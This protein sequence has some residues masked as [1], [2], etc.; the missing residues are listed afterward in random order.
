MARPFHKTVIALAVTAACAQALAGQESATSEVT[1]E[2]VGACTVAAENA[3]FGQIPVDQAGSTIDSTVNLTVNCSNN[4]SYQVALDPTVPMEFT[5]NTDL[6]AGNPASTS[7]ISFSGN[8]LTLTNGAGPIGQLAYWAD[9]GK[10]TAME[11]GA[12]TTSRTGTG[13]DET[14]PVTVSWTLPD[15]G[16]LTSASFGLWKV[17]N[18]YNIVF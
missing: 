6:A 13:S 10:T 17:T 9:P 8:A 18:T 3:S 4:V 15:S 14:I 12:P 2:I 5:L 16:S 1:G 7:N 11:V